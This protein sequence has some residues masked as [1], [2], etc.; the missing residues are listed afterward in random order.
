M[1]AGQILAALS[2]DRFDGEA[3]DKALPD[4]QKTTLY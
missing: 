2:A 4:R 3:Y 1:I